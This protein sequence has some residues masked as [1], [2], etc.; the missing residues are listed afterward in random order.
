MKKPL[1]L[2]APLVASGNLPTGQ[3]VAWGETT[4]ETIQT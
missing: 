3:Q 1:H 2:S 4:A